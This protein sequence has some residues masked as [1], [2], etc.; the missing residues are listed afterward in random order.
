MNITR[1]N[2]DALNAVVKI[3]IEKN[4]YTEQVESA[5]KES[6][7]K[8]SFKGFRPGM[9]PMGMVRKVYGKHILLDELN[10]LVSKNLYEYIQKEELKILGEPLPSKNNPSDVDLDGKEDFSFH[11]DIAF[12]PEFD[13]KL[14]KRDKIDYFEIKVTDEMIDRTIESHSYRYGKTE[15][16]EVVQEKDL[17]KGHF[18]QLGE[19]GNVLEG[20]LKTEEALFAVDRVAEESIRALVIG[21]KK[22]DIIDFD[23]TKAFPEEKDRAYMLRVDPEKAAGLVGN[24]R[25]T[26]TEITRHIPAELNQD[27]FNQ[28]Y[29]DGNV[30]SVDEYRQKITDEIKGEFVYQSNYKFLIDVKE[31][32]ISKAAITLPDEFLKRW[33]LAVNEKLTAESIENDYSSM[34]KEFVWQLIKG[35]IEEENNLTVSEEELLEYAKHATLMQFRQYGL[36]SFPEDQLESFAKRTLAKEDE[37]RNMYERKLEEKVVAYLKESMKL[38][39]KEVTAEEFNELFK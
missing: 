6:R 8:A 15:T 32:L 31:K 14:S 2:T 30:T 13:I 11:F 18:E 12:K 1:E 36:Y 28:V 35:K 4:D 19:D 33:L 7:K 24:F 10:K 34:Q 16:V 21:A 20:G 38:E 3:K 37:R 9:V 17:V 26:L 27:F 5:L 25:F 22:G 23:V 39:T 29:T